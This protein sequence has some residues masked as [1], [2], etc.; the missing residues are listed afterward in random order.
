MSK[1][2]EAVKV[3]VRCR[4]MN[5]SERQ[6]NCKKI[7]EIDQSTLQV[8]LLRPMADAFE[9]RIDKSFTFDAVY[10]EDST[11]KEVFDETAFP[12]VENVLEG[13]N[14]TIF[15]YGQTGCG[16]TFTME[17]VEDPPE[18]QGIIPNTFRQ[19]FDSIA[20]NTQESKQFLVRASYIEIYNEEVR[21][22]L[23]SDPKARLDLKEDKDRGV[24]IKGLTQTIVHDVDTINALMRRGNKNRTVGFTLMNADSSRSHSIFMVTETALL[25]MLVAPS[26]HLHPRVRY[27]HR[28]ILS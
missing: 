26:P 12:L 2:S 10:D 28:V 18:L 7:V 5:S 25:I 11:Q 14:G 15:A 6:R 17:G 9:E 23:G 22:L 16:K 24:F 21:D 13:Y 3:V 27:D 1:S 20:G 8:A 19:I 4:P